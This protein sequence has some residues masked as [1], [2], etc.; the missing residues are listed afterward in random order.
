MS[1]TE[2]SFAKRAAAELSRC[3]NG[4]NKTDV[5]NIVTLSDSPANN[6][7]QNQ[8]QSLTGKNEIR[9][10]CTHNSTSSKSTTNSTNDVS[11]NSQI[12]SMKKQTSDNIKRYQESENHICQLTNK[13][14]PLITRLSPTTF[15]SFSSN[16]TEKLLSV[17]VSNPL[18][19]FTDL[20]MDPVFFEKFT[21][22]F[23]PKELSIL[24]QVSWL[25]LNMQSKSIYSMAN[26]HSL[27]H[28]YIYI[29]IILCVY[30]YY[31]II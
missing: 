14:K 21:L 28:I 29:Y 31:T 18:T 1:H 3:F 17:E 2:T 26:I 12:S 20:L 15:R 7:V 8:G 27:T 13:L 5:W 25:F 24:A 16:R 11:P 6:N 30:I 10:S 9:I 4:F 19:K 22:F 23:T